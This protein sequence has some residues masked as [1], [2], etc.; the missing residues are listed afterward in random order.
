MQ[1]DIFNIPPKYSGDVRVFFANTGADLKGFQQWQ[2]PRG[3]SIITILCI[4]GGGGGGGGFTRI[5]GAAGGGGGSGAC[6]G[7]TRLQAPAIFFPDV[8]Y[9]QVGNGGQGGAAGA[10]GAAGLNSYVSTSKSIVLP[11]IICASGVNAP[12]GGGGGTGAAGGAAGSV[13]SIAAT[14]PTS[15]WG[16]W[17]SDVGLVGV[18]G[19]PQTGLAG[20][21]VTAWA[22]IPF[23]PGASGA[24]CT[25]TNFAGGAVNISGN[26]TLDI[27]NQ[28]LYGVGGAS[29]LPGGLSSGA[30]DGNAGVNRITPFFCS[31]GSGGGSNNSGQA[32]N[33]GDGGYGSGGGGGGAGATGGRGGNG[34]SGL[35]IIVEQ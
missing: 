4:A 22:T 34:G 26:A 25:T 2:K 32:G 14:Q 10:A 24:G 8:L 30:V 20:T 12:G 17:F 7:I 16:Y 13:P 15:K 6:S 21:A 23:S 1:K 3:A 19:G 18:I 28:G 9:I 31:G 11:N 29:L 27:G 5:A 33:G 35:V